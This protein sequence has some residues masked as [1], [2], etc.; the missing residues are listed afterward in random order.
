M[1]TFIFIITFLFS[2]SGY[3]WSL[4]EEIASGGTRNPS[5][6]QR[7]QE[8]VN[9]RQQQEMHMQQMRL[10]QLQEQ[11]QRRL[12]QQEEE[13]YRLRLENSKNK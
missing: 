6:Y 12:M 11:Q 1:R 8:G 10:M 4:N 7:Y 9:Q 3:T 13:L 2:T 5:V